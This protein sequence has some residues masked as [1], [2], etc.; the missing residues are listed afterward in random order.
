MSDKVQLF[1]YRRG[2]YINVYNLDG[3]YDYYYGYMVP[4][5]GYL[6]CFDVVRYR[7]GLMLMLPDAENPAEAPG[8]EERSKLFETLYQS[9]RWGD[10]IGIDT[11]GDLNDKICEGDLAELILVQE[12]LQEKNIGQVAEKAVKDPDR[13]IVMIAGPSSSGKTTFSHR[14]QPVCGAGIQSASDLRG[15][16][17]P[18][19]GRISA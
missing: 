1:K 10:Q 4:D 15:Q 6:E 9:T 3:Y 8:L 11:V 12:A 19:P 7:E 13:R 16:L 5:T 2:S 18:Q 17:F 14:L